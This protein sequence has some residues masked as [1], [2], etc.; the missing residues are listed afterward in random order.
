MRACGIVT[1]GVLGSSDLSFTS[2]PAATKAISSCFLFNASR[3]F[4]GSVPTFSHCFVP[5]SYQLRLYEPLDSRFRGST[6]RVYF[7]FVR[8]LKYWY[9]TTDLL[10]MPRFLPLLMVDGSE[11]GLESEH[12]SGCQREPVGANFG[13]KIV[14]RTSRSVATH[15]F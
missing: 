15:R 12:A 5:P 10:A 2:P 6:A 13:P 9:T 3:A 8:T 11:F 4:L 1:G 7:H 14:R